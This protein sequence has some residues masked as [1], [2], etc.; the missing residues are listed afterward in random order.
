MIA[1]LALTMMFA[2]TEP[3]S[4]CTGKTTYEAHVVSN[5]KV[6]PVQLPKKWVVEWTN[7][8]VAGALGLQ[9]AYIEIKLR[10]KTIATDEKG[11]GHVVGKGGG[12]HTFEVN[13]V[14]EW[15]IRVC[16]S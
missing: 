7:A 13:S 15:L 2:S 9:P 5:G 8:S 12:W 1:A 6:G 16:A 10:G 3:S 14:G 11:K 4:K